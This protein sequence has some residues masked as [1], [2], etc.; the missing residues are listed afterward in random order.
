MEHFKNKHALIVSF[1]ENGFVLIPGFLDGDDVATIHGHLEKLIKDKVPSMPPEHVFYEDKNDPSTL[2]QLQ[3]L[4]SYDPFFYEM[5]FRSRFKDLASLLLEDEVV[6]KN[7]QYFNKPPKK[8][9]ATPPHQDGYYFMLDPNEAV[10]MW[11]GLEDVDPENG[12]VRYIK[13]SHRKGIRAHA[14]TQTLGFSQ[15]ISDFGTDDDK[16][17]EVFFATKAGDL[18]VHHS[19]IIHRADGNN[20]KHRTR[21][22]L[23]LIYYA[24]R[25]KE[26]TAS[27]EKYQQQLVEEMKKKALI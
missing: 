25:A 11:L 14:K 20:S 22:A 18:L 24:A 7:M 3:N 27:K 10:T 13:G 6:P 2:K 12:C 9:Q 1:R 26:N 16:R 15:G 17:D 19:L 23:G 5:M 21:K 4:Y 8:G